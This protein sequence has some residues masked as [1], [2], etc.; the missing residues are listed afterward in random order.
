MFHS[1]PLPQFDFNEHNGPQDVA[2]AFGQFTYPTDK[3][4]G[5][6][7][8]RALNYVTDSLLVPS[9]GHR[10]GDNVETVVFVVTDGKSQEPDST[11]A[12]A[13]ASLHAAS[14]SVVVLGVSDLVNPAQL[15]TIAGAD[16]AVV[17]Q[18]DFQQ[19]GAEVV[20]QLGFSALCGGDDSTSTT[21][22]TTDPT[23]TSS[24]TTTSTSSTTTAAPSTTTTST[25]QCVLLEDAC[26]T[27][28]FGF[29]A[30]RFPS[31]AVVLQPAT[32]DE[33]GAGTHDRSCPDRRMPAKVVYAP[34][35][36]SGFRCRCIRYGLHGHGRRR[37]SDCG[38]A[39]LRPRAVADTIFAWRRA[40]LD[41]C[42]TIDI[43]AAAP[44]DDTVAVHF[45][46]GADSWSTVL[47]ASH[48]DPR[49][50]AAGDINGDGVVDAVAVF[51]TGSRLAWFEASRLPSGA[52]EYTERTISTDYEDAFAVEVLDADAD[53]KLD[54]LTASRDGNSI[55]LWRNNLSGDPLWERTDI[56]TGSAVAGTFD[57]EV[58]DV[59]GD[60]KPD[61]VGAH[62]D[63][64]SVSLFINVFDPLSAAAG[65]FAEQQLISSDAQSV[66][67]VSLG[68]VNLDGKVD[69]L[70]A[71]SGDNS[72]H[73]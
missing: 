17:L 45:N 20:T 51:A 16:G 10:T 60:G 34:G 29:Q 42:R 43:L 44:N 8:G 32:R 68:D 69:V 41:T 3:L 5:T 15:A 55:S 27:T 52:M 21:S 66:R 64:N 7:T 2:G 53:G 14:S 63:A 25:S 57:L 37:V 26:E 49:G 58:G 35:F 9:A 50:V 31:F 6:A 47:L 67:S 48:N 46:A 1:K 18:A 23:T 30:G 11:V 12:Q 38:A 65:Y 54:I 40:H 36:G 70:S 33:Q 72:V 56:A 13:A 28:S 73:W 22:S 62:R 39:G 19:L 4:H 24:T 59:N 61:F 71:S